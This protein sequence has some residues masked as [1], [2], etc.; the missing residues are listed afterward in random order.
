M[1]GIHAKSPAVR[2]QVIMGYGNSRSQFSIRRSRRIRVKWNSIKGGE[3][4][5]DRESRGNRANTL[6]NLPQE[7][8]TIFKTSAIL[9]FPRMGAQ[10]FVPKISVAM[11][12][13][14]E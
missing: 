7:T 4:H 5:R 9:T 1:Q 11:L 6:D 3:A 10:E 8:R 12:D 2:D 14:H 13:V